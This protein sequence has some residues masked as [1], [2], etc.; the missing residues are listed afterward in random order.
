MCAKRV[1][2]ASKA[3]G[4]SSQSRLSRG[5]RSALHCVGLRAV[6]SINE[7]VFVKPRESITNFFK[8]LSA[9]DAI[10][11]CA[12]PVRACVRLR[13]DHVRKALELTSGCANRLREALINHKG[14]ARI[15]ARTLKPPRKVALRESSWRLRYALS[16]SLPQHQDRLPSFIMLHVAQELIL[17]GKTAMGRLP[18]SNPEID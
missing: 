16:C 15:N 18:N 10:A 9:A 1:R 17:T 2:E 13:A 14:P 5:R 12:K 4:L 3:A 6:P 8:P 11:C 7:L